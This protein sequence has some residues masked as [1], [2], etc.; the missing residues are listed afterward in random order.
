[1]YLSMAILS[2]LLS[3]I[4]IK[5]HINTMI[6]WKMI[7]TID[8]FLH[9]VMTKVMALIENAMMLMTDVTLIFFGHFLHDT[10]RNFFIALISI[11]SWMFSIH[12]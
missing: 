8:G 1:M 3:M 7:S 2:F 6:D 11:L 9:S 5:T 10:E 12:I 4:H